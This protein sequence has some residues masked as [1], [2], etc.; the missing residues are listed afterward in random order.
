MVLPA[1]RTTTGRRTY[2]PAADAPPLAT[3]SPLL[4]A[5]TTREPAW[6]RAGMGGEHTTARSN[7]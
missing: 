2:R 7:C 1:I 6:T 4:P 3:R 5:T